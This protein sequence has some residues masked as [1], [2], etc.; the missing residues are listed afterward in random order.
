M[1]KM[2]VRSVSLTKP[3]VIFLAIRDDSLGSNRGFKKPN[4]YIKDSDHRVHQ[5]MEFVFCIA[6][7]FTENYQ[8]FYFSLLLKILKYYHSKYLI[9]IAAT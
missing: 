3:T 2:Y 8:N 1:Y 5:K 7:V 4:S 6:S 9:H